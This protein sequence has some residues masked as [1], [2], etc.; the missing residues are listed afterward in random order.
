MSS[1]Y[2]NCTNMAVEYESSFVSNT[3]YMCDNRRRSK[4]KYVPCQFQFYLPKNISVQ[5]TSFQVKLNSQI[6]T[7][8]LWIFSPAKTNTKPMG[9]W[10]L[11]TMW[12][13]RHILSSRSDSSRCSN[14]RT[15]W[16][17][18]I[19]IMTNTQRPQNWAHAGIKWCKFWDLWCISANELNFIVRTQCNDAA[20]CAVHVRAVPQCNANAMQCSAVQC[21]VR[22][23]GP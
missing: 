20:V 9:P 8:G 2:I 19:L 15:W 6:Y 5:L 21:N 7:W 16:T 12:C 4:R 14:I 22:M 17:E 23:N 13:F 3:N 18:V 11:H 10:S 1:Q